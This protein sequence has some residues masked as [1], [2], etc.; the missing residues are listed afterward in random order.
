MKLL[1]TGATGQLG[2][3]CRLVLEEKHE[4]AAFSS[5]ELDITDETAVRAVLRKE[6]PDWIINCAAY[7]KVDRCETERDLAKRVNAM[8]PALLAD[9]AAHAGSRLLHISTDYVF[10]GDR[11]PPAPYT[12]TDAVGPISWYGATKLKG[13]QAALAAHPDNIVLRTAWVYGIHGHNFLKTMLK[14]ALADPAREIRVVNDQYGSLT[15]SFRLAKQIENLVQDGAAQGLY[16]ATADGHA[17]WFEVAE[18]FLTLMEAPHVISPCATADYP[19]P[20]RRPQNSILAN[21][22]LTREQRCVMRP[23]QED[24]EKFAA[25][26]RDRLLAEC[27]P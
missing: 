24:L 10:A 1:L 11:K 21:K 25:T 19:T 9:R 2:H 15:W 13:E 27:R 14:L 26:F 8:A 22:R 17:T 18:T 20:A 7:T 23:W 4:V 12:E 16:H 6:K 5:R 3:D